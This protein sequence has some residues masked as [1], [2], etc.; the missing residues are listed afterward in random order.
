MFTSLWNCTLV[1]VILKKKKK[2]VD[3]VAFPHFPQSSRLCVRVLRDV[4]SYKKSTSQGIL[5]S[6]RVAGGKAR[7]G[8]RR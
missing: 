6:R 2:K 1:K 7:A 3:K 8:W 5:F 4:T